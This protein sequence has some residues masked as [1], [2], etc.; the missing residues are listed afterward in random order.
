MRRSNNNNDNKACIDGNKYCVDLLLEKGANIN[1]QDESGLTPLH[2]SSLN[3][4]LEIVELLIG[5]SNSWKGVSDVN[6]NDESGRTALH[7]AAF[8]GNKDILHLLL[9]RDA[10]LKKAD[11]FGRGVISWCVHSFTSR[12]RDPTVLDCLQMVCFN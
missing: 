5:G 6:T 8:A 10:E 4:H 1:A 7:A 2:L 3:G 9:D 11:D 12:D